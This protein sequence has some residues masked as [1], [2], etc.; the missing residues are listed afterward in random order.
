MIQQPSISSPPR[1]CQCAPSY[2]VSSFLSPYSL[3]SCPS[4]THLTQH[5]SIPTQPRCSTTMCPPS[6]VPAPQLLYGLQYIQ[7]FHFVLNIH[8]KL[9]IVSHFQTLFPPSWLQSPGEQACDSCQL[10]TMIAV[11]SLLWAPRKRIKA[12]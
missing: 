3:T 6:L 5:S 8:L 2:P 7:S 4:T 10:T 9:N 11:P 12:Y 1:K